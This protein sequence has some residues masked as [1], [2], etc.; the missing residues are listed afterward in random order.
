MT[1]QNM[2]EENAEQQYVEIANKLLARL[3][4]ADPFAH[5]TCSIRDDV[6]HPVF[7]FATDLAINNG[8]LA[9]GFACHA[10]SPVGVL[11]KVLGALQ[12]AHAKGYDL[13]RD[14][15]TVHVYPIIAGL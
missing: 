10:N 2:K 8:A 11:I 3:R 7:Y 5:V 13:T 6:A 12:E 15:K 9:Y 14:R 1:K 4:E